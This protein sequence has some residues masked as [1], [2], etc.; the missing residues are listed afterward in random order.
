MNNIRSTLATVW[1]IAAPYFRSEDKWA[2]RGLLAAVIA[3]ELAVVFLTVLFNRWN[4]VFYNALQEHNQAVFTYQIGYF[5]V[6]AAFW[7]G[8][9][10]LSALPQPVAPDPLAALDD[11]PL[12][13]RLAARR[14]SLSDA[15]ARRRRRQPGPAHRRGYPAFRRADA[16]ARHRAIECGRDPRIVHR[17]SL[18]LVQPRPATSVRQGYPDP[19]L[20]GVG[21]LDLRVAR[22]AADPFDRL[23]A[24]RAQFPAT[25]PGSRFPFQSGADAGKRRTDRAAARRAR[26]AVTVAVAIWVGR[27][28]LAR[29]HAAYQEAD[30]LYRY[31]FASFRHRSLRADRAGFF[32]G[33]DPARRH[34]A[35]RKR[36]QQRPGCAV[37]FH[38]VVPDTRRMAIGGGTPRRV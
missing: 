10:G 19:R 8:A 30:G 29:H 37:V 2:G 24:G 7:I 31:L 27:Q 21:R 34:D 35:D 23:A 11:R 15:A 18:G 3:I 28:Q 38:R 12:S 4:N 22:D 14:Q 25:A 26:R 13:R 36:L 20:S 17:H 32:C 16:G 5:C 1:R 6:L 33:K 9:E